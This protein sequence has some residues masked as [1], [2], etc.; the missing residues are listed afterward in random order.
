MIIAGDAVTQSRGHK[1]LVEL[2]EAIGAPVYVEFIPNTASFPASH[3]LYRGTMVRSQDGVRDVLDK[4]D[5]LFSV[6]GDMFTWSLPST[7]RSVAG[8]HHAHPSRQRSVANRQEL[9]REGRHPR[10]SEGDAA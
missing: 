2:A 1:E 9:S 8:R 6:G 7:D 10:R 4:H 5:L 3:P